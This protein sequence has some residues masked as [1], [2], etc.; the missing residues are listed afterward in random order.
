MK[1]TADGKE[2]QV[3]KALDAQIYKCTNCFPKDI[4]QELF[5]QQ[6]GVTN[7]LESA[8]EGYRSCAFAFGQVVIFAR[9]LNRICE[10]LSYIAFNVLYRHL[11]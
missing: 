1:A 6:C 4:D 9:D 10:M 11:L 5:F 7:L 3:K 8:I 2:V